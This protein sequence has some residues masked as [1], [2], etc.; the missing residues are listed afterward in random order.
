MERIQMSALEKWKDSKDRKPLT[1]KGARQTGK[2]WL[3]EEFGRR[4]VENCI[5]F[6]FEEK[7]EY[8]QFLKSQR[9]VERVLLNLSWLVDRIRAPFHVYISPSAF[10]K[11]LNS[12]MLTMQIT[13]QVYKFF[14]MK[15]INSQSSQEYIVII[16]TMKNQL[17]NLST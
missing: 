15:E 8:E 5:V 10:L 14:C 17:L 1:A 6:N 12:I 13:K 16:I 9:N 2:S 4:Y 3:V 11:D 7:P